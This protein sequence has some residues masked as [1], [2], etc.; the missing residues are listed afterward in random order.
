[1]DGPLSGIGV[2]VTRPAHQAHHLC[3]LIEA[4]GG[5]AIVLPALQINPTA[6]R[7]A[8]RA[9]VGPIDRY[10]LVIFVSA[11]AVRFGG[12]LIAQR[13]DLRIAAIGKATAHALNVAGHRVSVV[14]STGADSESLL[15]STGLQHMSGQRVLIVRG[16][17]GRELLGDTLRERGAE[18]VYAEVYE[19]EPAHPSKQAI[20]QLEET[21]RHGGIKVYTATSSELLEALVGILA[22]RC[23]DLMDSTSLLTGAPRVADLAARLGLGS[24][25]ILA[26][27]ADDE[28]LVAA[29]LEWRAARQRK[30]QA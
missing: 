28:A 15:A 14:P 25:V 11:N 13:R 16:K 6:D 21:W 2:L 22:P 3:Q 18:V 10:H 19:R 9:A 20:E 17:G 5:S 24:P 1:M 7:P 27:A 29:L 26:Q 8:M 30:P 4:Q 23:R 12:D